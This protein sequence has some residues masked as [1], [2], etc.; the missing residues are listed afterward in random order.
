VDA[1]DACAFAVEFASGAIGT[2]DFNRP[3]RVAAAPAANYQCIEIHGTGGAAIYELIHR[4]SCKSSLGPAMTRTQ[5]WARAEVPS[6][7]GSI[8][9]AEEPAV[10]DPLLGY[11]L[12]QG[13]AFLRAVR[14]ETQEYPT[15]HDGAE[16][17]GLWTPS[18]RRFGAAL[19]RSWEVGI[20]PF[21]RLARGDSHS[22]REGDCASGDSIGEA[23]VRRRSGRSLVR[24][25]PVRQRERA[26]LVRH[27]AEGRCLRKAQLVYLA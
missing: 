16:R 20:S 4:S 23:R 26:R 10:D 27:D 13:V 8:P 22:Q 17:R 24:I 9:A 12:D 1:D 21:R 5:Q 19:D 14:G 11:K 2:F 25:N 15:F 18:R 6:T 7:S 3:W